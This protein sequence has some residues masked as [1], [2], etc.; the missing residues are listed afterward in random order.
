ML[1]GDSAAR[2]GYPPQMP[3]DVMIAEMSRLPTWRHDRAG[4]RSGTT[5]P[6][7]EGVGS[8]RTVNP[9]EVA[10]MTYRETLL[11]SMQLPDETVKRIN[12]QG[13]VLADLDTMTQAI[14]DVYCGIV[15]DHSEPNEKDRSQAKAM[16]EA[17]QRTTA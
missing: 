4:L 9:T 5:G 15:A 3:G 16:L 2:T 17:L 12:A 7:D 6:T 10:T 14:H 13:V 1:A 11:H 8:A